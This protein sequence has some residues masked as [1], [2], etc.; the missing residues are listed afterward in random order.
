[1]DKS[2]IKGVFWIVGMCLAAMLLYILFFVGDNS[3]LNSACRSVETPIARSY[4]EVALHPSVNSS[5]SATDGLGITVYE[6]TD[7][8][9]IWDSL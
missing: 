5:K 7:L 8:F 6:E 3:A 9:L 4:Y 1:M 2:F